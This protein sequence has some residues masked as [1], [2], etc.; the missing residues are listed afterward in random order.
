MVK[1]NFLHIKYDFNKI[2][3][4][5]GKILLVG[6]RKFSTEQEFIIYAFE[7]YIGKNSNAIQIFTENY[8]QIKLSKAKKERIKNEIQ[9]NEYRIF[10][11]NLQILIFYYQDKKNNI[12]EDDSIQKAIENLPQ[13]VQKSEIVLKLFKNYHISEIIDIYEFIEYL[14]YDII[15]ANVVESYNIKLNSVQIN[16]LNNYFNNKQS[17]IKK[18]NLATTVRK[19]ISRYLS[20]EKQVDQQNENENLFF[21]LKFKPELWDKTITENEEYFYNIV[22]DLTEKLSIKVSNSIDLYEEL[23]KDGEEDIAEGIEP[24]KMDNEKNEDI[25]EEEEEKDFDIID[26]NRIDNYRNNAYDEED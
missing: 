15:K 21:I 22:D 6:K 1:E 5:L 4:E 8:H 16:K 11:V 24:I 25:E 9:V 23:K 7:G 19:Y 14:S 20:G 26:T 18:K 10:L 3:V 13:F 17:K 2:E 12:K